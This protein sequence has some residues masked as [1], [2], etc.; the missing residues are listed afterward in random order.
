MP[1]AYAHHTFG[2]T[3]I[4]MMPEEYKSICT[5]YRELFDFGVHGPDLLFYYKPLTTNEIN[6]HGSDMHH[7]AGLEFF[8]SCKAIYE[9]AENKKAV[10]AYMLGFLAHFTLDSSCHA[11]INEMA[12]D[13]E[14]SHNMIEAQYEA[15]LMRLDYSNPLEVDR[16]RTLIPSVFNASIVSEV[17]KIND[18]KIIASMR[19]QRNA[20]HLFYSPKEIKKKTIR[21]LITLL[22]IGGNFGDLFVDSERISGCIEIV[23]EIRKRHLEAEDRYP[24]LFEN[25]INYIGD[26]T[27]LDEYFRYD[28]EGIIHQI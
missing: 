9:N 11:Y 24:E 16:S 7:R 17:L 22:K 14:Y 13:T 18:K 5:E 12:A 2:E 6:S 15:Y 26:N 1:A 8:E 21:S 10:L 4:S 28:F 25:F 3:C 19:G 27:Q 23:K 20:L